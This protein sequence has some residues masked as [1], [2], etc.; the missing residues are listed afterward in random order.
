MK[1][2]HIA[3]VFRSLGLVWRT[4]SDLVI[5]ENLD[6]MAI[7]SA[8]S[9]DG[10]AAERGRS[11]LLLWAILAND[12]EIFVNLLMA[13]FDRESCRR[14]LMLLVQK[15]KR[16]LGESIRGVRAAG[17]FL[18]AVSIER[19]ITGTLAARAEGVKRYL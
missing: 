18:R 7:S 2:G 5:L 13:G 15:K 9:D 12:G 8:L 3:D 6:A 1:S 14:R 17:R 19:Q 10:G 4:G 11:F 16:F